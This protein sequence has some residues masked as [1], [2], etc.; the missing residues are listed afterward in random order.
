MCNIHP[1]AS[2]SNIP[3]S[4][5]IKEISES[6]KANPNYLEEK[7]MVAY[8]NKMTEF[9]SNVFDDMEN[10]FSKTNQYPVIRDDPWEDW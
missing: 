4:I 2:A 9:S 8:Q 5:V 1:A 10:E 3:K 7:N 6:L